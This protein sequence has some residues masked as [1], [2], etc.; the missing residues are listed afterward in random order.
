M[1]WWVLKEG[2]GRAREGNGIPETLSPS[3]P[4]IDTNRGIWTDQ[5]S[6]LPEG[7]LTP[8]EDGTG[9]HTSHLSL[10][11]GTSSPFAFCNA[12]VL[13]C[14]AVFPNVADTLYKISIHLCL[15]GSHSFPQA[16]Y[17]FGTGPMCSKLG[18]KKNLST[19][20][21]FTAFH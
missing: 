19:T 20:I 11:T 12:S 8:G 21:S 7:F 13:A 16:Y 6:F 17:V 18:E 10:N 1:Q 15:L 9:S 4:F 2:P 5:T 14:L 3:L